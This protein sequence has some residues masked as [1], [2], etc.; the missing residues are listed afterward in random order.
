[1]KRIALTLSIPVFL[2][3]GCNLFGTV[4]PP[5][6]ELAVKTEI[7]VNTELPVNTETPVNTKV[8]VNTEVPR[9]GSTRI[10]ESDSMTQVFVP[11][12][13][14]TMGTDS[15]RTGYSWEAPVHTVFLDPYWIDQTEVTNAMFEAFVTQSGY[16]TDAEKTGSSIVFNLDTGRDGTIQGADWQHPLGPDSSLSNLGEHPVVHI[17]WNDARAYCEW[18]GRRLPTE[19][20]WEK[21]GRG[22]DGRTFPWGNNFDGTRL[23]FADVNLN[24]GWGDKIFDDGFQLTSPV[25]NYP[26]GASPY[27]ALDMA[28]NV[29]EWVNDWSG[30][31]PDFAFQQSWRSGF[32]FIPGLSRRLVAGPRGRHPGGHPRLDRPQGN[33]KQPRVSMRA[34]SL[35]REFSIMG[36]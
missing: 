22:T 7:P 26:S 32:W 20:E 3:M 4:T 23:N 13:D 15:I 25:G 29:R 6:T 33:Q 35:R 8:P 18:A 34:H 28:G 31:L 19:A 16:K 9:L 10:S 30:L 36:F 17:S 27:G 2:L 24:V 14:F 11:G 21:A 12:G 5:A 1:M